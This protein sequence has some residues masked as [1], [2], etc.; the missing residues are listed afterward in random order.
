MAA[1]KSCAVRLHYP[2]AK[3]RQAFSEQEALVRP[4]FAGA[5]ELLRFTATHRPTIER[6]L[7][8]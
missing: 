5:L 7:H 3:V 8:G 2:P 1:G 4:M 6:L